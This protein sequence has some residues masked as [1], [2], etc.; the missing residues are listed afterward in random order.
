MKVV[1]LEVVIVVVVLFFVV[2]VIVIVIGFVLFLL[3]YYVLYDVDTSLA[4]ELIK[5]YV[6][7]ASGMLASTFIQLFRYDFTPFPNRNNN[8]NNNK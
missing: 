7:Q 1:C 6:N 4:R 5:G 2:I 8:G 3:C